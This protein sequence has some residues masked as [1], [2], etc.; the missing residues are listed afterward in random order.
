VN[1]SQRQHTGPDDWL[2]HALT[3]GKQSQSDMYANLIPVTSHEDS[4]RRCNHQVCYEIGELKQGS[5]C[6]R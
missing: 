1:K 3:D 5:L 6:S 2:D 4:H